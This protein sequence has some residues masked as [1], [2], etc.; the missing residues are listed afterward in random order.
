MQPYQILKHYFLD[1]WHIFLTTFQSNILSSSGVFVLGLFYSNTIVGYYSAVD[2][3][4]RAI[5]GI[6]TPIT[7]AFFPLISS[8]LTR[9][10]QEGQNL[11]MKVASAVMLVV[12][13]A[14]CLMYLFANDI[15]YLVLGEE[16]VSY[17]YILKILSVYFFFGMINNFI[18]VQYLTSIGRSDYYLKSFS[19]SS[20]VALTLYLSLTPL[21][22]IYGI[23][24]GMVISEILLTC[25]MLYSI[26][27]N[28][29][30]TNH[31]PIKQ[32]V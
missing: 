24:I 15:I 28:A 8:R 20:I 29:L 26:Q 11:L 16:F 4:L 3:L 2:K 13:M 7:Q 9:S 21:I 10:R 12:I 25:L 18:G 17:S 22:A 6:F 19:I 27:K 32:E 14:M 30:W 23:L 1:G 5:A 31:K